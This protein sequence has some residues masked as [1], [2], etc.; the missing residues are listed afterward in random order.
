MQLP[1]GTALHE[2]GDEVRFAWFPCGPTL[3]GFVVPLEDGGAVET[4]LIGREGA[5]GGIV[6]NGRVPAFCRASVQVAG[7][8][9]RI[10]VAQLEAAKLNSLTLSHLFARY[11]DCLMAQVFQSVACNAAHSLEQRT[12][13]WLLSAMDRTGDHVVPL[14]QEQLAAMLGVGRSYIS[15][16]IQSFKARGVL[17]TRRGALEVSQPEALP[18]IARGCR[19]AVRRHFDEVL[20]GV[21]PDEGEA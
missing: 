5:L 11:A 2:P 16:V 1:T 4:A 8:M 12:A 17:R 21:Y 9:L 7:P 10:G 20:H 6:S 13:K 3:L 18:A 19:D 14:T 15:R